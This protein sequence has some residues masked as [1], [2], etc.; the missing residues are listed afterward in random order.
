MEVSRNSR[1]DGK[2]CGKT[3]LPVVANTDANTTYTFR[4]AVLQTAASDEKDEQVHAA[5]GGAN[6]SRV[7]LLGSN[8]EEDGSHYYHAVDGQAV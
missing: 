3:V 5:Q 8:G 1:C 7:A 4:A 6:S 2:Q